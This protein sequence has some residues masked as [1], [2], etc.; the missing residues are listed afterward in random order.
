MTRILHVTDIHCRNDKLRKVF[1]SASYDLVVS[2]G[3]FECVDTVEL[4][5]E[6]AGAPAVAVTGNID[7]PGVARLLRAKGALLDG[8]MVEVEG[9]VFAGIGGMEVVGN[10]R[11]LQSLSPSSGVD[12]LVS[13]HPPRGVLDRTFIGLRAGLKEL[14][15]II[16]SL[17]PR[18][19]VFGHIHESSGFE[20]RDG[21]IFVNPGP[22]AK[23]RYA[24]IDYDT[25]EV[26]LRSL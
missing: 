14:W 11:M 7:N 5:L 4:F 2:S 6:E 1:D 9:L 17:K 3:D 22:L 25:G 24:V 8:R 16:S 13:H 10:I 26:E 21:I 18:V 12:V 19:H 15:D 20:E 23:G